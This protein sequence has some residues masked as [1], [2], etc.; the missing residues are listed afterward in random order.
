MESKNEQGHTMY[1]WNSIINSG[2]TFEDVDFPANSASLFNPADPRPESS[3]LRNEECQEWARIG[4]I[5][6]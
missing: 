2:A 4:E 1:D 5:Y 6:G 3:G